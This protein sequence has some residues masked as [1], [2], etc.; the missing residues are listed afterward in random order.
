[1][2]TLFAR[3]D[4]FIVMVFFIIFVNVQIITINVQIVK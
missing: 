4:T 1:M 3:T 2:S